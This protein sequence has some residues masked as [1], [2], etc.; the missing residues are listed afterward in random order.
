MVGSS[1]SIAEANITLNTAV[2]KELKEFA[3][4]LENAADFTGT[5]HDLIKKTIIEHKKIIFNGNGYNDEWLK[6][7]VENRKL[8]N[9]KSTPDCLPYLIKDKNVA[10]FRDFK[11]FTETEL[12]ARY[13][14]MLENYVKTIRIEA[15]TM[16]DMVNRDILPAIS[17]FTRR[18]ADTAAIKKAVANAESSYETSRLA[19]LSALESSILNAVDVL[20]ESLTAAEENDMQKQAEYYHDSVFVNM[21]SLRAVVDRAETLTP[22]DVWPFPSYGELLFGVR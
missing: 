14:I 11:V 2:A 6:E 22:S 15:L 9:L 19:E 10:L 5:L 13:E 20:D 8:L 18:L 4:E 12:K 16:V 21:Q 17:T 3:D 1:M 7:A